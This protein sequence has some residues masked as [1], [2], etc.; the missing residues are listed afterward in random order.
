MV[1]T[2]LPSVT[3]RKMVNPPRALSKFPA[4]SVD[5]IIN[6]LEKCR[7]IFLRG[8]KVQYVASRAA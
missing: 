4:H 2:R 8:Q 5:L 1:S 3:V 6:A 7:Q